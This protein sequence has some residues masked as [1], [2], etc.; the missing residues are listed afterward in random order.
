M[1]TWTTEKDEW[2]RWC[3]ERKG[4]KEQGKEGMRLVEV[5]EEPDVEGSTLLP[6]LSMPSVRLLSLRFT[7]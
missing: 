5:Q 4:R 1:K 3:E 7:G 2:E 6:S